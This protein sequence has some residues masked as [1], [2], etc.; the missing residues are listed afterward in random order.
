MPATTSASDRTKADGP[1]LKAV[2]NGVTV[3]DWDGAGVLDNE[4]HR[5]A[6]VGTKGILA[7][8]VHGGQEVQLRVKDI[9]IKPL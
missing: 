8:Q 7:L 6:N 9:R 2:L 1:K 3:M 5:K 4:A